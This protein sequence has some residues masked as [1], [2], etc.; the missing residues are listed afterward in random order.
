MPKRPM[1]PTQVEINDRIKMI[2]G[3]NQY[4]LFTDEEVNEEGMR[5]IMKLNEIEMEMEI[6]NRQQ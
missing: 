1:A 3:Y 2:L 4:S 5:K 6:K